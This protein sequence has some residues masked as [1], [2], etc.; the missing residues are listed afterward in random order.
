VA[1]VGFEP[2][3]M[4]VVRFFL[5]YLFQLL[6]CP[7]VLQL[8][9]V[10]KVGVFDNRQAVEANLG[11]FINVFKQTYERLCNQKC[12]TMYN[13]LPFLKQGISG[14]VAYGTD[15]F[16]ILCRHS[17]LPPGM[18]NIGTWD[19]TE[20]PQL[21]I[22]KTVETIVEIVELEEVLYSRKLDSLEP[23]SLGEAL[24][25]Q[26]AAQLAEA[27]LE[28]NMRTVRPSLEDAVDRMKQAYELLFRLENSLRLLIEKELK[29]QFGEV[30]WWEEGA[31]H[32]AKKESARNQKDPRW[33]W[34]DPLKASPLNYVDFATLHDIIVNKN[35]DNFKAILG[36]QA[37]FTA[38]FKSLE[39]PR[40]VIAHNNLLSQ[41]EFYDFRRN[42]ERLLRMIRAYLQ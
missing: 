26:A 29:R 4:E 41:E 27:L 21:S 13:K 17:R 25:L 36:P 10:K 7:Y 30:D 1:G 18:Y 40:I 14:V 15:A 37:T 42:T 19:E 34:H 24:G 22:A 2:P 23:E 6:R 8:G 11:N 3:T 33:K 38:T 39:V 31:T 12:P 16:L 28:E 9:Q 35:W 5:A 20:Y 32:D